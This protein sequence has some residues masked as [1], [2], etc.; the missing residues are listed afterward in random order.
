M[1]GGSRKPIRWRA[2]PWRW[3]RRS[4]S[5]GR[6]G[7]TPCWRWESR[8]KRWRCS[9]ATSRSSRRGGR[10]KCTGPTPTR[11]RW[12][13]APKRPGRCSTRSGSGRE[14]SSPRR[15]PSPPRWRSSGIT[16]RRWSSSAGR[17]SG[18]TPG[19]CSSPRWRATTG[20]GG[21]RAP[22]RCS[23]SWGPADMS[24]VPV[25]LAAALSRSYRIERELGQGGMATVYLA[26]DLKHQ[27]K[28]AI[29]VLRQELSASLGADRFL[30]EVHIAAQLQ[31][32]HILTLID[33]GEADDLLYYVMP[34][35][36]GETLR[37]RLAREGEFPVGDAVRI[38][39]E[40]ADALAYAHGQ[41]VVHRD[42]KPEN[43]M[44]S[45]RHALVMDFGVAKAVSE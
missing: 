10:R 3:I 6:G 33:S 34:Y 31:H 39:R 13:A 36:E 44:L 30:R 15:G 14:G 25:R 8:R 42:V 12:P 43:V 21:I 29:K 17:L 32:P 37:A 5:P 22:R 1:S 27:R 18:M 35:V 11:W 2:P 45:G 23:R 20:C 28:G 4:S 41:G 24:H 26:E 9:S 40:V 7:R 19:W 38:L 16:R